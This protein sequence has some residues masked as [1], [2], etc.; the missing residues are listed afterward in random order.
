MS[1]K[2]THNERM[3][4]NIRKCIAECVESGAQSASFS[5][6]GGSKGYTRYSLEELDKLEY[7]YVGR[8]NRERGRL[9][10]RQPDFGGSN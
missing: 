8:V 3:L 9:S 6:G 7:K 10:R 2:L 1:T 4:R 5:A